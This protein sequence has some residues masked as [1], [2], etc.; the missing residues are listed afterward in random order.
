METNLYA[1]GMTQ[2]AIHEFLNGIGIEISSG[3]VNNIL[4]NEAEGYSATSEAILTAGLE[5][6]LYIRTDDTGE[7]HRI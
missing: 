7:K 6:A 1:Q 3:Q 2:P 5:E 4:L